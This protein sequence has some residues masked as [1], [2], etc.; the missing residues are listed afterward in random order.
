MGA[1]C[2]ALCVSIPQARSN[3]EPLPSTHVEQALGAGAGV[4]PEWY[5]SEGAALVKRA[6]EL[7][8]SPEQPSGAVREAI[9]RPV[10]RN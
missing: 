2:L 9:A 7:L 6:A 3:P 8:A 10:A 1:H 5:C 4:E